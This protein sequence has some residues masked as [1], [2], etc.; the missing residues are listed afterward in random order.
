MLNSIYP[1]EYEKQARFKVFYL[2][3]D[4]SLDLALTTN[5][6]LKLL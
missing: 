3:K 5:D 1:C 2:I 6:T 4:Y